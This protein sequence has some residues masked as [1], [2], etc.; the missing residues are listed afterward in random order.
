MRDHPTR[1]ES[2]IDFLGESEG[3]PPPSTS[4]LISGCR[5]SDKWLLVHVRKLHISPSRWTQ[6]QTLLAERRIIHYST[7]VHWRVQN[8]TYELGCH[9]RKPH[10]RLLEYRWIKRFV[11]FLDMLHSVF[12]IRRETS[13]RIYVVRVETDKKAANIQA[14]SFMARALE[15]NGKAR[16][17]EGKAKVV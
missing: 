4:R 5:W 17:A 7:E 11:W 9:A 12:S 8:Y 10:R 16:Q 3:S 2:N 15:V 6:S 14:R 1:G 13:R